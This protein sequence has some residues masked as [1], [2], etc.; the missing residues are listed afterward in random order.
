V[1]RWTRILVALGIMLS[2]QVAQARADRFSATLSVGDPYQGTLTF[3]TAPDMMLIPNTNV[4]TVRGNTDY[5]LYRYDGWFYLV[6]DGNW[7]RAQSWRGPFTHIEM[8]SV[9]RTVVSI[10]TGYRRTW[11][12]TVTTTDD[13]RDNSNTDTGWRNTDRDAGTRRYVVRETR[14]FRPGQRYRGPYLTFRTQ[15]RMTLVPGTRVFYVRDDRFDRDLYRYG[16]NWYYVENGIWYVSDSWRGPFYTTR[17]RNVPVTLRRL[18]STY[19]RTWTFARESDYDQDQY[20]GRNIRVVRYGERTDFV[21]DRPP[22]MSIIPGTS[23]Y[24]MRDEADYDLYRYGNSWYLAD[25]GSW[26]RAPSWRGPFIR[27]RASAVPR[28]VF[29]IPS[30]YRKT[31]VPT[32]D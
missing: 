25:N 26:Y 17:W 23:V 27:V 20:H 12:S 18:P 7:Y 16:S 28:S 8:R 30:G 32:M 2:L 4:Y 22:G 29:T 5:D 31:W 15:P 3:R 24:F 6:D 9:P 13:W 10:P 19:R 1:K 11:S 14:T 21:L